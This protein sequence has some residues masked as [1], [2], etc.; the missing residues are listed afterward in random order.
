M[1]TAAALAGGHAPA[2]L[3]V[4]TIFVLGSGAMQCRARGDERITPV[5]YSPACLFVRLLPG[6]TSRCLPDLAGQFQSLSEF[7]STRR[8]APDG[9]PK[10]H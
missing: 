9:Q 8:R 1:L 4:A 3:G 7:S 10:A 2:A 5:R 6:R